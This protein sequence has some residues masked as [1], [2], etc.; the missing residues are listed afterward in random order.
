MEIR[1]WLVPHAEIRCVRVADP[2]ARSGLRAIGHGGAAN[3]IE[4]E[5][6]MLEQ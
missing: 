3:L 6:V 2:D 1:A 5:G 4:N